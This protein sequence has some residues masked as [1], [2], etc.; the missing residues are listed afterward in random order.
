LG[1]LGPAVVL[2]RQQNCRKASAA[3]KCG[4]KTNWSQ[5]GS[6][7]S[8]KNSMKLYSFYKKQSTAMSSKRERERSHVFQCQGKEPGSI[9]DLGIIF[10]RWISDVFIQ[11]NS[12]HVQT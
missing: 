5:K 3:E 4:I 9:A 8:W 10:L 2:V 12:G 1:T 11:V 7:K 6:R